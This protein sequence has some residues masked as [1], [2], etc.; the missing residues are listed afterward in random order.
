[1]R[2]NGFRL[3]WHNSQMIAYTLYVFNVVSV[4][5]CMNIADVDLHIAWLVGF[6]GVY[7]GLG[8]F[9]FL[10]TWSD[11]TAKECNEEGKKLYCEIC[12]VYVREMTKHC[13]RCKRCVNGF[14]HHCNSLNNCIGKEN[15]KLFIITIALLEIGLILSVFLDCYMLLYMEDKGIRM[16]VIGGV[17]GLNCAVSGLISVMNGYLI[18]FH[19]YLAFAKIT[20]YEWIIRKVYRIPKLKIVPDTAHA[21]YEEKYEEIQT[22][23][24]QDCNKFVNNQVGVHITPD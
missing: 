19:T 24:R 7:L 12:A 5:V 9:G 15:Y 1:M 21:N 3:P 10:V 14:D 18:G 23:E 16:Y 8:I 20:T 22:C 11:P 4:V 13:R 2:Q 17:V 6:G